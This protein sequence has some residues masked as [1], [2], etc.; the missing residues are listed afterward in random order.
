[1]SKEASGKMWRTA[2]RLCGENNVSL[3]LLPD[4]NRLEVSNRIE[5][6]KKEVD[7]AA[8]AAAGSVGRQSGRDCTALP[9]LI[10]G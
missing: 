6:K 9:E 3:S 7:P 8:A 5:K 10:I 1:M 4:V 2:T